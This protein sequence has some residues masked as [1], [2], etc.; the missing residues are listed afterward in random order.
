MTPGSDIALVPTVAR[1]HPG[2]QAEV[3]RLF[4]AAE[5][6]FAR[7]EVLKDLVDECVD[8]TL[9]YRQSGHPGG[10][11]SK[12]HLMLALA[13]SGAMRWDLRRPW[14]RFADR[15]VLSA[16]HTVPLVYATLA[17]LNEGLRARYER[18]GLER[19]AFADDGRFALTWEMLPELRHRGGLPGHAEMAGKSLFLKYNTGPSGHG[20]GPAVGEALALKMAG[21][22][23]VKVFV[24]EGEGGLTPGGAH[25]AKNTAWGLGLSNLVF[26]VDWNDYG[27]DP[28]PASSVVNGSPVD[29]FAP[30]GWRVTGT[31]Q[32]SE[33]GPVTQAV[34]EVACGANPKGAP[35]VAWFKTR[36]GRGYGKYDAASHGTPWPM[37]SEQFWAVRKQFMARYGVEYEGVGGPAPASPV[38]LRAQEEANLRVVMGVLRRDDD[39]VEWLSN[40]LID[41]AGTVPEAIEGFRL[42]GKAA[43]V[44]ADRRIFDFEH[45]PEQIWK[46]PGEKAPNRAAL[47]AWG[48]YVNGLA[49]RDYGRPLFIA[50]SADL[51][52]STNI[53]GFGADFGEMSG[54]GWYERSSNPTGAL[55]PTEITEFTNAG[56]VAG[57]ATVGMAEDP[58]SSFNGFWGTCSTYG[59][60]SYLKY[61]PFRLFSQ[62]AQDCELKVG[63]VLWVAGHS[64]PET[65]DDSRTHF[66]IF[67]T[68]VTQLFPEGRV[69]DLHPWEH[70]EVPVVLGAALATDV[71][72]VALHLTRP[73]IEI[74]DRK[75]L[76]IPSHFAA[77]RGAYVLRPFDE[78]KPKGGTVFVRGTM[79]THNLVKVLPELARS[80]LNVKVV[81]AISPQLFRS[82]DSLYRESVQSPADSVDSMVVTSGAF[83]LMH[84][85]ADGPITREYSLSADFDDRWRTGGTVDEVIS[86]AHLDSES[87]LAA[88]ERFVAER[89]KRLRRWQGFLDAAS[90]R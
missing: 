63:K 7:Y 15:F 17:V 64:G 45:Y 77:A 11:R 10:S 59:S 88:I 1:A 28:R 24:V 57:L 36:K 16:G 76:G 46:R 19:Y 86:E 5:L 32:G 67:E 8:L 2:S 53:S 41:I 37:N 48:S 39:L 69:I 84:H 14:L 40:R 81:A 60:F 85:W 27:I 22:E 34:L 65:A 25:E 62:L 42:G 26:L 43:D 68:G 80:G 70:N 82:Q 33:W 4:A 38:A 13:L 47:G 75:A 30:Y 20:M 89:A 73:A 90:G 56:L 79:P 78:D 55:L 12:V 54:S 52:D 21:A 35:S 6:D 49:Q 71:P 9:N 29:W 87:I 23:A 66:G 51:A 44:F 72:I 83:K 18:S 58:F 61:G 50:C 74:P 3:R 31:E